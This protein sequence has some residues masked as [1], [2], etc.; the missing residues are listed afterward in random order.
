[1]G[2]EAAFQLPSQGAAY[3]MACAVMRLCDFGPLIES[4]RQAGEK[5]PLMMARLA[6]IIVT[7]WQSGG[8]DV[9][10]GGRIG[11]S[12][13]SGVQG[14]VL[15]GNP[16][17]DLDQLCFANVPSPP[18]PW[19]DMH[20]MLLEGLLS[21]PSNSNLG[22]AA[23]W[24]EIVPEMFGL[25]W[26]SWALSRLHINVFRVDTVPE[27]PALDRS[28]MLK[29]AAA[30]VSGSSAS[31]G[32]SGVA[33]S[34]SLAPSAGHTTGG[35]VYLLASMLNHSCEPNLDV[36]FP[37]NNAVVALVAARS[38]P[39]G[40]QLCISYVDADLAHEP[41]RLALEHGYGF[42]SLA[43]VFLLGNPSTRHRCRHLVLGG[44]LARP[45][46]EPRSKPDV[47]WQQAHET[48]V[49]EV[50]EADAGQARG[51]ELLFYG[52]S[53]LEAYR[54]TSRGEPCNESCEG[55]P[56]IFRDYF[57]SK[58]RAGVLAIGG[59]QTA[60]LLWRMRHGE[61]P[62]KHAPKVVVIHIG[63]NDLG[64]GADQGEPGIFNAA[65][66]A[67]WRIILTIR[68][69]RDR[70]PESHVLLLGL[71]PRGSPLPFYRYHQPSI[72]SHAIS[73]LS[74]RI[75][76]ITSVDGHLHFLDCADHFLSGP[77]GSIN[78]DLMPDALHPS[79]AGYELL[80]ECMAPT[81]VTLIEHPPPVAHP[82]RASGGASNTR[83]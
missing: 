27:Q 42:S 73:L 19:R 22:S 46:T 16:V 74:S 77:H 13:G 76:A 59:D 7:A 52:D 67:I 4:C 65:R 5:L 62:E 57:G 41:R 54:G 58:Y 72:Y 71:L 50:E 26:Y 75:K 79:K 44:E 70:L 14:P 56:E 64:A 29:A 21:H 61:V 20:A 12:G 25:D 80:A 28:A 9:L 43:V 2:P 10:R 11:G 1:M 24:R 33:P 38:I 48:L 15:R 23:V 47:W 55:V 34:S 8:V 35:A 49:K 37:Y 82:S 51:F 81:I 36:T 83:S 17:E 68:E 53:I 31:A 30:L 60:H 18:P 6:C 39:K 40:E 69:L 78:P 3:V 45:E 32:N 66:G 63:T